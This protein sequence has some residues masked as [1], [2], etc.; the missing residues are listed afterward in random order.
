[1]EEN[2]QVPAASPVTETAPAVVP[3]E[4]NPQVP[5]SN[6][7]NQQPATPQY[8]SDAITNDFFNKDS[9]LSL[10]NSS[11]APTVEGNQLA[12][13]QPVPT[14]SPLATS[15]NAPTDTPPAAPAPEVPVVLDPFSVDLPNGDQ[16]AQPLG[17][18]DAGGLEQPPQE[19]FTPPE[20]SPLPATA[21]RWQHDAY[22]RIATDENLT[23]E[24][25]KVITSLPV[26][27]WDRAKEWRTSNRKL[28]KFRDETVP[29]TQV[30]ELLER[31]SPSRVAELLQHG[32]NKILTDEG[33]QQQ[34]V[35]KNK[36]TYAML[37]QALTVHNPEFV[38]SVLE[39][40]G[41]TVQRAAPFDAQAEL[42][43]LKS[44]AEWQLIEGTE[45]GDALVRAI[46]ERAKA[47][48]QAVS[49]EELVKELE[50]KEKNPQAQQTLSPQAAQAAMETY[51]YVEQNVFLSAVA[52]GLQ[53]EGMKLPTP[54]DWKLNPEAAATMTNAYY[55]ALEGGGDIESW[56]T[57]SHKYC[58]QFDGFEEKV[59]SLQ[60]MIRAEKFDDFKSMSRSLDPYYY[61]FGKARAKVGRVRASYD[62]AAKRLEEAKKAAATPQTPAPQGQQPPVQGQQPNPQQPQVL[63]QQPQQPQFQQQPT[64]L[65]DAVFNEH[66]KT[67]QR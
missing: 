27:Q 29:V 64:F 67:N 49:T 37:M 36:E 40:Q 43:K 20:G 45:T 66:W 42:E 19:E 32:V 44:R 12:P 23:D 60:D 14:P 39:R 30:V 65:S 16:Q 58:K 5:A 47:Q 63:P 8:L 62:A 24:D 51:Q 34:F 17:T 6:Q 7:P 59:K 31:E 52:Q 4:V 41:Y 33:F 3:V 11:Q 57:Q 46:E 28:G 26:Q 9:A 10:P 22:Q 54:N 53:A 1:M 25:K 50:E 56:D 18:D 15:N 21:P 61:E 48:P 38:S 35:S 55:V 13:A 2:G